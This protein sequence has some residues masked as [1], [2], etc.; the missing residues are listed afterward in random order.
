MNTLIY[1]DPFANMFRELEAL[2]NFDFNQ[3]SKG[4][5]NIRRPHELYVR[6]DDNGEVTSYD[7]AVVYTPFKK[8]DV[9]LEVLDNVL[10][11]T[12]GTENIEKDPDVV[13]SSISHQSYNFAL[14]L[15]DT[16]DITKISA[17]A[18]DGVLYV[19]LP[20]KAPEEKKVK[21]LTIDIQ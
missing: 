20:V 5:K 18:D 13:F 2:M 9:K 7:L 1:R 16:I 14:P 6:K 21:P 4:L 11:V 8:S 19:T 17:K 15:N 3:E 12:C 10:S